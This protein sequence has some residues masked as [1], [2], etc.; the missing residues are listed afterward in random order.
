MISERSYIR[1]YVCLVHIK[2]IDDFLLD[3]RQAIERTLLISFVVVGRLNNNTL[4][5]LHA[6]ILRLLFLHPMLVL[7]LDLLNVLL[8]CLLNPGEDLLIDSMILDITQVNESL[9]ISIGFVSTTSRLVGAIS[10]LVNSLGLAFIICL[11][12]STLPINLFKRVSHG[13]EGLI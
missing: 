7:M 9:C 5:I 13:F 10:S 3:P 11:R 1:E 12:D 2:V 6:N 8:E 4:L